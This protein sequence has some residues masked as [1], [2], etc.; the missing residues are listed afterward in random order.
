MAGPIEAVELG[1]QVVGLDFERL[2]D[3]EREV[4]ALV[5]HAEQHVLGPDVVVRNVARRLLGE[6][7]RLAG[8]WR[9][10]SEQAGPGPVLVGGLVGARADVTSRTARSS[11]DWQIAETGTWASFTAAASSS[12]R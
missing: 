1:P 3:L 8:A 2:Q 11:A 9:E 10:P 4:A 12:G 5:E 7:D 6:R